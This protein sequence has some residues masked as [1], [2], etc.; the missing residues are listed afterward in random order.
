MRVLE[1]IL[2]KDQTFW[3]HVILVI[4]TKSL[5]FEM[6]GVATDTLNLILALVKIHCQKYFVI[7]KRDH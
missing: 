6:G 2:H 3:I 1:K 4:S 7:F 5:K